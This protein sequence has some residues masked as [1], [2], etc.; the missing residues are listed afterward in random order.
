MPKLINRDETKPPGMASSV[1]KTYED[2]FSYDDRLGELFVVV[3]GLEAKLDE[4]HGQITGQLKPFYSVEEVASLVDRSAY[5]VR[6]W[7][8][9]GL[10]K[11]VRVPGT[12]S[13]GR[14]L[15]PREELKKLI[16]LGSARAFRRR[17]SASRLVAGRLVHL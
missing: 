12:G 3:Q 11:A 9:E 5:T 13:K 4:I 7:V 17:W 16:V 1:T 10:I 2:H 6:R 15:I 14:L 8:S